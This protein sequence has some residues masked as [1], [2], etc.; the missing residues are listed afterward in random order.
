MSNDERQNAG[1]PHRATVATSAALMLGL[2]WG[3]FALL[4]QSKPFGVVL[5]VGAML[6]AAHLIVM[7]TDRLDGG[8]ARA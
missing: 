5:F 8:E 4:M 6:F 7:I 1:T 2:A 3:G